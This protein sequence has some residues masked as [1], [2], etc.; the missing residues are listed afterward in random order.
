M[1]CSA[2]IRNVYV[3][4]GMTLSSPVQREAESSEYG[5]CRF[6]LDG[7]AVVFRVAKTTPTKLG[8]FVTLWK[9]PRQ[10]DAIAPL[11]A[12]DQVDFVVIEVAQGGQRGQFIFDKSILIRKGV[13]FSADHAGKR[14][15]RV[16]P[17]WTSPVA[18]DAVRT[19]QWQSDYFLHLSGTGSA[20][21]AQT[22][23]LFGSASRP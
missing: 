8:Q 18:R 21:P 2:A 6:G 13:L 15:I 22:K 10:G 7:Q 23:R 4:A 17:P 1:P 14:A 3:A 11:A 5:A 20:D 16:Y 9:R 19:Q 12:G